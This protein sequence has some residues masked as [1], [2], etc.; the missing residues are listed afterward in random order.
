M[1]G[2]SP[3]CFLRAALFAVLALLAACG[4]YE[5]KRIREL[6]HEKGFGTRADGQATYEDYIGGLDQVAFQL[7][8]LVLAQF[9]GME[10]LAELT[11]AQPVRVDGTIYVPYVGGVYVLGLTE[12][13][14]AEQ[15]ESAL[16]AQ[17]TRV[18]PMQARIVL[19]RKV[20]YAIGE[21]LGSKGIALLDP[22]MTL[23]DAVLKI[24][25]TNLANL[26][27]VYLI[28]PDAENP[29]V[30]EV[31]LRE[32]LTSGLT[33]ANFQLRE[34]DIVYIPPTFLGML[35]RLLQRVLEP[36][37]L[38]V[39]TMLGIAQTRQAYDILTGDNQNPGFFFRF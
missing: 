33:A 15:V 12:R 37:G 32:M 4:S 9:P 35:A 36:V 1:P 24:Q 17:F 21:V 13:Q 14:V 22:D 6:M 31:N 11:T 2:R 38:G 18:P 29:L 3:L 20:F 26:G 10:R 25:W 16:K 5:E 23:L 27:R 8:P 39:R 30:V 28:R 34:R 19:S 7:Q